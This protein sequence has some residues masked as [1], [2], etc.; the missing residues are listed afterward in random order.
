MYVDNYELTR[1]V[2]D[3]QAHFQIEAERERLINTCTVA[4]PSRK[5]S[6]QPETHKP[7]IL[8]FALPGLK[9]R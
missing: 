6:A 1:M 3:K 7:G 2:K 9:R 5:N 4:Q 8:R